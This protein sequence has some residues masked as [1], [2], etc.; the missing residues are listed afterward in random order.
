MFCVCV[1][2]RERERKRVDA[3]LYLVP[4][5]KALLELGLGSALRSQLSLRLGLRSGVNWCRVRSSIRVKVRI[6][7]RARARVRPPLS[8]HSPMSKRL[9]VSGKKTFTWSIRVSAGSRL[10]VRLVWSWR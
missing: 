7:I 5:D 8:Q 4:L 10:K 9:P 2:E 6:S 3:I 1:C